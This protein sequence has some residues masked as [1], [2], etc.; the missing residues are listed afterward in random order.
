MKERY[1]ETGDMNLAKK[2][3]ADQLK[4]TWGVSSVNGSSTV[5]QYPP[6]RAPIYAGIAD[7]AN[8]IS[9][10]AIEAVKL[11]SGADVDRKGIRLAPIPGVTAHAYKSGQPVPYMLMWTD[12]DG[13]VHML[14]PGKAFVADPVV[15]R[16]TQT[17]QRRNAFDAA[18]VSAD[19]QAEP[20]MLR[21]RMNADRNR[22]VVQ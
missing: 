9:R 15:M 4:N 14:N 16:N 17:D 1:L 21:A 19:A 22:L 5:M 12:K 2:Q 18:K 6:E 3:A 10:Q 8:G 20:E 7:S 11:E 13:V